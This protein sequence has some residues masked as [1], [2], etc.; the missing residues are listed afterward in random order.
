MNTKQKYIVNSVTAIFAFTIIFFLPGKYFAGNWYVKSSDHFKII[1]KKSH[2]HLVDHILFSAENA[3]D[4]LEKIFNY[5]PESKIVINTIDIADY[6]Y[7]R[8]TSVPENF[9]SLD[10][11]PLET[12]YENF[13]FHERFQWL[14]NHELVH[15]IVNDQASKAESFNR[16]VFSKVAPERS[17]PISTFFSLL[18]NFSRY[19]PRWHQ[20]GIAVFWETWLSG[21]FGRVLGNFDEMYFRTKVLEKDE[22][23]DPV[24]LDAVDTHN[25][26]LLENLFYLYGARFATYLALEYGINKL[27]SWYK[28][29]NDEFYTNFES[30]FRKTFGIN[31]D[32]AWNNFIDYEKNFQRENIKRIEKSK[33]TKLKKFTTGSFG[34]IT[35][36]F[37]DRS[38]NSLIFGYHKSHHLAEIARFDLNSNSSKTII[39]L[40]SPSILKVSSLAYDSD[41]KQIF[42]TTNNNKLFRDIWVVDENSGSNQLLFKDIRIGDLT[43]SPGTHELWGVQHVSGENILVYSK[44][45]YN[46][47]I[48]L[49]RFKVGTDISNLAVSP[50]GKK[51]ALTL[52][53]TNGSQ[54]IIVADIE[55]IKNEGKFI[56]KTISA[57]GSPEN[58][59]WSNNGKQLYWN[60]Y[61][62]GVSNIYVYNF[63]NSQIYPL[64]NVLTGLFKPVA[65]KNDSLVAF[66]FTVDGFTPVEIP[67]KNAG[68]IEAIEY[69]GQKLF[70][71]NPGLT[72]LAI[73]DNYSAKKSLKFTPQS[74]YSGLANINTFSIIP[75]I[76]GFQSQKVLGVYAHF[77]D[78]LIHHDLQIEIG[79]SPFNK[80]EAAP[81]FHFKLNY[82][83]KQ[84]YILGIDHNAPDFYDLFNKRKRGVIGTKIRL[85]NKHYWIYDIPYKLEQ[86]TEIAIYTD[87]EYIND[88]LT[89]VSEPDFMVAQTILSSKYLRRSIGSSDFERGDAFTLTLRGFGSDPNNPQYSGQIIAEWE[90]L[91][92][93]LWEHNTA[94]FKL[95]LGYHHDNKNLIQSRFYF[96]GFGNRSLENAPV[97]Q[98]RKVFRFPGIPIYSLDADRFVKLMIENNF[99]P[100]RFSNLSIGQ[101]YLS[102]IDFSIYSQALLVRSSQP[103]R[104]IDIGAQLNVV[105]KHWFNLESTLSFGFAKAWN[106]TGNN[107]EWFIS[108]KLLKS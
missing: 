63:K 35:R 6:G 17:H 15:I 10:I 48:P 82:N 4:K 65:L 95:G 43:V 2:E 78:P 39:T 87:F 72:S 8:A 86:K 3:L 57:E 92:P 53:E 18:T 45:P 77:A 42:Y 80:I 96:G 27:V 41:T 31:F 60:A 102:H 30:K 14:L 16:S 38:S 33:I 36:P 29:D 52:H 28:I 7:G 85:G 108:Y 76:S 46:K 70:Y 49:I 106:E 34:W 88:N 22:F 79:Y 23:P 107:T 93:L 68:R 69:L 59:G 71:K 105:F 51:L 64:S 83:Y 5:K 94:R 98:Y 21:G 12:E 97:K 44:F 103:K 50:D 99:P 74:N 55:K 101:Q 73:T 56:F 25:S 9:I 62:N 20:E 100:I 84:K 19:T 61:T 13:P 26:F 1:Y 75:M 58:P 91:A 66:E 40:P 32:L 11:E 54:S 67:N 89:R 81:K 47:M 24:K 90:H 37:Y 104:W